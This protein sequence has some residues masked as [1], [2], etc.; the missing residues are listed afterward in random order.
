MNRA[1]FWKRRHWE[2]SR[3]Q[4]VGDTDGNEV[5]IYLIHIVRRHALLLILADFWHLLPDTA[6]SLLGFG[7]SSIIAL[8]ALDRSLCY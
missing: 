3:E 2:S 1:E 8:V 4:S 5:H 6:F 7:L